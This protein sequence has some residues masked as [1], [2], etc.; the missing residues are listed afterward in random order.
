MLIGLYIE[1]MSIPLH[2]VH[3]LD[4]FEH[5][6]V[7]SRCTCLVVEKNFLAFVHSEARFRTIPVAVLR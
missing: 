1:I 2:Q 4:F 3:F 7:I 5:P 6:Q